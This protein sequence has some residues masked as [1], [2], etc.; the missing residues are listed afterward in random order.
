MSLDIGKKLALGLAV[1]A[2][3]AS[4]S[5]AASAHYVCN[6]PANQWDKKACE[7]AK[8][9]SPA[10]LVRY[11]QRLKIVYNM[12]AN[13]YVREQDYNRWETAKANAGKATTIDTASIDKSIIAAK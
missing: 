10:E 11:V 3:C 9:D 13:D 2:S 1:A 12:D 8:S 4:L 5:T 6:A 7:L